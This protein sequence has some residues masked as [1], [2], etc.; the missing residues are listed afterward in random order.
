MPNKNE[1]P[2][3]TGIKKTRQEGVEQGK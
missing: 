3:S 1:K 2:E